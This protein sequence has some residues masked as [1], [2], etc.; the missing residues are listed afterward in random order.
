MLALAADIKE[1]GVD[2]LLDI[3][4][5][6][7]KPLEKNGIVINGKTVYIAPVKYFGDNLGLNLNLGFTSP[8][9]TFFCR[10][11]CIHT[12][13][14]KTCCVEIDELVRTEEHYLMCVAN[15]HPSR[16]PIDNFGVVNNCSL[17]RLI[18][19]KVFWNYIVDIMHDLLLGIYSYDVAEILKKA[20][21]NNLFTLDEFNKA[22][23]AFDYGSKEVHYILEDISDA[24]LDS[25]KIRGHAREMLTLVRFLPF[26]LHNLLSENHELFKFSLIMVDILD[27][28]LQ[29][30]F[31]ADDLVK[32]QD[33]TT[34]HNQ[35][36][37]VLFERNLPPKAHNILHYA[38]VIENSG[39]LKNIWSMRFE[40]KH[41][42][43]K[44]YAKVCF[45]RRNLP[46]SM[47][48]KICYNNAIQFTRTDFVK[49]VREYSVIR[50]PFK[51]PFRNQLRKDFK[52]C[53]MVNY[54]G[55][56]YSIDDYII[57]NCLT[58]VH[59][60][61]EIAVDNASDSVMIISTKYEIEYKPIYRSYKIGQSIL[62]SIGCFNIDDFIY[63]ATK[64]H[65][66]KKKVYIKLE[67]F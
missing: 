6:E 45:S 28:A 41:Q 9:S 57:S 21:A 26:I 3:L 34:L 36:Y 17:N 52:N 16:K 48:K 2:A 39:P 24:H 54:N 55:R 13:A 1:V 46:L 7:L 60:V 62:S 42:E 22:K 43:L 4:T 30:K 31:T 10:I 65:S 49:R 64:E 11:C 61:L 25:S 38:R 35:K 14:S 44:A 59:K 15:I 63:P 53:A 32:L 50:T 23:N 40:A 67:N 18:S 8:T 12:H 47:G 56:V 33:L 51:N 37:L 29:N 66:F 19:F 20:V 5:E 27:I 58:C